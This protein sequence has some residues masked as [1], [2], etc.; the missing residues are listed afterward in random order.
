[1]Q[2]LR[3]R[4]QVWEDVVVQPGQN[5]LSECQSDVFEIECEIK[6]DEARE[7]GF[8]VRKSDKEETIVGYNVNSK[9]LFVDRCRSGESAFHT[10]FA[11]K[12]DAQVELQNGRIKLHLFVDQASIEVFANDGE[13]TVTDQIFPDLASTGLEFYVM[14]GMARVISLKLYKLMSAYSTNAV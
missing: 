10:E 9:T 1:M 3:E 6:L 4:T 12:H 7:I 8:K 5:L 13:V 14:E 11:C 2:K